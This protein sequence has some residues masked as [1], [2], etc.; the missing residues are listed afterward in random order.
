[1]RRAVSAA[2]EQ[3][4]DEE[5]RR[6]LEAERKRHEEALAALTSRN[7][8]AFLAEFETHMNRVADILRC[9]TGRQSD[10]GSSR[11]P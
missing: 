7:R 1:M 4:L 8:T 11:R 10:G 5:A 3:K 9:A 6:E 2:D